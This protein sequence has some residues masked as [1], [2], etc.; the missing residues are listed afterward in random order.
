MKNILNSCWAF[1][2][3]SWLCDNNNFFDS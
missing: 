1:G 3:P 2:Y